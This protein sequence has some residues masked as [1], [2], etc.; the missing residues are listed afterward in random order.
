MKGLSGIVVAVALGAAVIVAAFFSRGAGAAAADEAAVASE[1]QSS[2]GGEALDVRGG[3][4]T[5]GEG[6]AATAP[7]ASPRLEVTTAESAEIRA[8]YDARIAQLRVDLEGAEEAGDDAAVSSLRDRIE[9]L[10]A[11]AQEAEA[12]L[13]G[14]ERE[15]P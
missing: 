7:L 12:L 10:R 8:A 2:R 5:E 14:P 4:S 9:S 3:E 15:G 6:R 11:G 13:P 1:G